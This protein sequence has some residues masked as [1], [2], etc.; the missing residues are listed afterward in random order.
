MLLQPLPLCLG[1]ILFTTH[2]VRVLPAYTGMLIR[3]QCVYAR[4]THA[5][6]CRYVNGPNY[7]HHQ[8]L[9]SLSLH[10]SA[11]CGNVTPM[12]LLSPV[13]RR[14]RH[15]CHVSHRPLLERKARPRTATTSTAPR[16][17]AP[18]SRAR[19]RLG[20]PQSHASPPT[21]TQK[22]RTVCTPQL[23]Y[24]Y[25][26]QQGARDLV[27]DGCRHTLGAA[28]GSATHACISPASRMSHHSCCS[29]PCFV[30]VRSAVLVHAWPTRTHLS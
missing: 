17:H 5:P 18:H 28:W 4:H 25:R 14:W 16:R 9:S 13:T 20:H 23:T 29:P 27:A 6:L 11:Q 8:P 12:C 21:P 22:T 3:H 2:N 30:A 15:A 24:M 19:S 10:Q 7:T 1:V 26:A